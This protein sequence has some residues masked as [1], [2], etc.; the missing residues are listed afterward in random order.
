MA[1]LISAKGTAISAAM[2]KN[3]AHEEYS[4]AA[5]RYSI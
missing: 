4:N 3:L 1:W 2:M 5:A